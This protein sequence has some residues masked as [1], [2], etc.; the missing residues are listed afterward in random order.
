[1]KPFSS[2]TEHIFSEREK[3]I[4]VVINACVPCWRQVF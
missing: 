3:R 1:M 2:L 4:D